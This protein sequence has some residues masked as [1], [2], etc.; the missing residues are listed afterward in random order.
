MDEI[1]GSGHLK[2]SIITVC[3]NE[4]EGIR[5]TCESVVILEDKSYEWIVID[6]GSTDG[7]LEIL[8]EYSEQISCLISEKDE[9]IYDAM[10]K[11]IAHARGDYLIFMNGGDAFASK[12]VLRLVSE[13]PQVDLIYGDLYFEKP[14]GECAQYPDQLTKGYLLKNMVP[15]QATFYRRELFSKFG[16]FDTSYRIAADYELFIRLLELGKVS[17]HHIAEPLAVFDRTGISSDRAFRDLRKRENHRIRKQYFTRY[18]WSLKAFRQ[19]IRERVAYK[20]KYLCA[21]NSLTSKSTE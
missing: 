6:G 5:R 13:A 10:N 14:G 19:Y 11:G 3:L 20:S 16:T 2:S 17:H 15:H 21:R 1:Q 18:R 9:G 8:D 7:T 4:C 12:Q